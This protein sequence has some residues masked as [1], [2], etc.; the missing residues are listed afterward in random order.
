MRVTPVA[1]EARDERTLIDVTERDDPGGGTQRDTRDVV[2]ER[3]AAGAN[4]SDADISHGPQTIQSRE[5]QTYTDSHRQN[6]QNKRTREKQDAAIS[7]VSTLVTRHSSFVTC[8]RRR[9][10][11]SN[12]NRTETVMMTATGTPFS[13]VG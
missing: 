5:P 3:D 11:Y 9:A 10:P 2:G 12:V 7:R 6:S 8:K 1:A 4:E 13:S